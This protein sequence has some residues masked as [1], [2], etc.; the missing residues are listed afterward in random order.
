MRDPAGRLEFDGPIVR[1]RLRQPLAGTHFL[2]GPVAAAM[3][4]D[5]LVT[6]YTVVDSQ[7]L[8]ARRLP[9]VTYPYEWT[10]G[11]LLKA[12][13]LTLELAERAVTAGWELK[14]AT[15]FNVVFRGTQ[16][17]FCDHLSFV[18]MQRREWWA[19]GQFV[20]HFVAPLALS[21]TVDLPVAEVFR[22]ALDGLSPGA[23]RR[24][25]GARRW[26][27]RSAFAL[28]EGRT[29]APA[30]TPPAR[31]TPARPL[32]PGLFRFLGW[33]LDGL[34]VPRR[35]TT[36]S[37]YETEREHYGA[38]ALADKRA[39]V[40]RWLD[41][42]RPPRVLDIGCNQGEFSALALQHSSQVICLDADPGALEALCERFEGD[43]RVH[44][45]LA[46]LD[47][48]PSGRGW[49][50]AEFRSLVDR[51]REQAGCTLA[52]AV[53]HHLVIGRSIPLDAV[54]DLFADC[55]ADHL[56]VEL[57]AP[58]DPRAAK[59]LAARNRDDAEAFGLAQQQ[60]ALA[61]RFETLEA[62]DLPDT[63]R[64]LLL[65]QKRS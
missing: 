57:V 16:P 63:Q 8:E 29:A 15:A 18:P 22:G 25:L 65:M 48:P 43:E 10:Y 23:A 19:Y 5:G 49:C 28:L 46:P 44:P 61:R 50:G 9:F 6:P 13:R 17:E 39:T 32:H 62:V 36:W 45:V 47:D 40:A 21:R 30:S 37:H 34:T 2:R 56:V 35:R 27:H 20:R 42:L 38:Q 24:L 4:A 14:D 64:R 41:A 3:V 59:L 54:A 26:L 1:R 7:C 11:Q 33:Q 12:A 31:S 55:T 52:L 53:L 60:Q 51:L 58:T